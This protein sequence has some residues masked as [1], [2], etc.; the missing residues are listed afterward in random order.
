MTQVK[1]IN[2]KFLIGLNKLGFE[3]NDDFLF[4]TNE[5]KK[6][7]DPQ[8]AFYLEKAVEF[9]AS[10]VYL[11]KQ[12]NGSYKPQAY[13]FDFTDKSFDKE[14]QIQ[15]TEI[16]KKIWSSGESPLACIFYNTE[17]K[18][19]NC[20]THINDDY[21]PV[22]LINDLEITG[23][24]DKL[25]NEQFAIKIKSG[26][27]W[28]EEEFKNE[29]KFQNSSYDKLIENIRFIVN[30]LKKNLPGVSIDLI[31]KII[32]Q[33]ILI[34]YLEERID[35]NGNKLLSNKYFQ[36]YDKASTFTDVLK[37][38]KFVDLLTDLDNPKT[39]FNG[40]VFKWTK[41]EQ[42]K[43]KKINLSILADL[44][45]AK[46]T[47]LQSPQLNLEFPDWRYFEF[48]YIPVELISRLYEEFL[49]EE[50]KDKGLYYTPSH[51]AKL[52]ID[53]CIPL[54]NYI[55]FDLDNFTI[56]DPACGSGIFLVLAFKRLVQ[57][58]RLK[59]GMKSPE[60]RDLKK[61]LRNVYGIDKEEQAIRLASFSLCLALCNELKPV[62]IINKL[63]FDD[64][65][66]NNLIQS[67]F[68][69]C[70][71]IKDKKFDLIIGNPPF[72]RGA[73]KN[74]SQ[75]WE[76][77]THKVNIPQGQI[78]LKFL[79]ESLFYLKE[80]ALLC[81][82]IKSSGLLYNS[83]SDNYKNFL[84]SNLN[85]VQ[86]LDFTALARNKSLWDNGAD[87]ASAAIFIRNEKPDFKK[88]ILHLTFKRTKATVERI[89][90]EID[91]YDLHFVNR[92]TAIENSFIW[93]NN[94]LGGGRIKTL[95]QEFHSHDSLNNYLIKNNCFLE[96]GFEIGSKQ[97]LHPDFIY[98]I[99]F[100]PTEAIN[101]NGI[102]YNQLKKLEK[103]VKFSKIPIES[104]FKAPSLIIWESLG[105]K[106]FPMFYNEISFSFKR[107]LI[108]IKSKDNN[109]QLLNFILKSFKSNYSFY[110]FYL[111]ATSGETLINR[112]NTFLLKD[113]K[114]IPFIEKADFS[115]FDVKIIQDS[116]TFYADFFIHGE[117]S[118][119]VKPIPKNEINS[120]I[121]DYG[122][123]F[124]KVLNL[125][126]ENK[127]KKF[128]LS[129]I[130]C[131][132]NSFIATIFKY[133]SSSKKPEFHSDISKLNLSELTDIEISKQLTVN[134]II[135]LYPQKDTIVFIKPNQYRYWLSLAAYRDADKCFSDLSKLNN[136]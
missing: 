52:L 81:L 9:Q 11:R 111:L 129:D 3:R 65:R 84:F 117:N 77:K 88:N 131:L 78:A 125:V 103:D 130:V 50:K 39:G 4:L 113:L 102:D 58:W 7:P 19:L 60:L 73:I 119:A 44:L 87:V 16:Q 115:T 37:K 72:N 136:L 120:L 76:Y 1:N 133:D 46:R 57:I 105:E 15:L 106:K 90:F 101:E 35:D 118:K 93:K 34:K 66:E 108:S 49:G 64:L 75:I 135:K 51:L 8:I 83:S 94:L 132:S 123:E 10:A 41:E 48:K 5:D 61:I 45:D 40:N 71:K 12:L 89:V 63:K 122:N 112:N 74:Y 69:E 95:V 70:K 23:N 67:D 6:L 29:F 97:K 96:E 104:A 32:V 26:I 22:H 92:Q 25:Y 33:S 85:I 43:L 100:L 110:K 55:N 21:T 17:I 127:K 56:L 79:S 14:N 30:S 36:K 109:V 114:N 82:I 124:S 86:L 134:R 80:K 68:F 27:F 28:E 62:E 59:N 38:G 42:Q 121:I 91:D 24:V 128:R 18:I 20:T 126:Y 2:I 53:E 13:L 116:I 107:R 31:N 47:S 98:K 99:P 54:K